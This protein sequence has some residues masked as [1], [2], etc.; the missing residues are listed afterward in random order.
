MREHA[1]DGRKRL[2]CPINFHQL[3][4][5]GGNG[6]ACSGELI[7]QL[8]PPSREKSPHRVGRAHRSTPS[9]LWFIE[10]ALVKDRRGLLP[11]LHP[12][13]YPFPPKC[14]R[15]GVHPVRPEIDESLRNVPRRRREI[16]RKEQRRGGWLTKMIKIRIRLP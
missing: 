8:L 13:Q 9:R 4:F 11:F 1:G 6:A 2:L 5:Y 3:I 16:A 10:T 14:P 15:N 12:C 7:F